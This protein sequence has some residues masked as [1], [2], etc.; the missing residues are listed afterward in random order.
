MAVMNIRGFR[1][2]VWI[3]PS[4]TANWL[5][6]VTM[7]DGTVHDLS[8]FL[9]GGQI[10]DACT[11][12][13]GGFEIEFP[14]ASGQFTG[15]FSGMEIVQ[16][17][18]DYAGGTPSTLRF[19][20]RVEK[21]SLQNH[22]V[23]LSGRSEAL[24]LVD[25][26]VTKTYTNTD[27]AD[28]LRD[29][30]VSYGDGRF[31]TTSIPVSTGVILT[32][33]WRQKSWIECAKDLCAASNREW[34]MTPLLDIELFE[35]NSVVNLDDAV[36]HT[37]NLV[38]VGEFAPDVSQIKNLVRV[39]GASSGSVQVLYT[40]R[41]AA[42]IALYGERELTVQDNTIDRFEAAR[43]YAE[44]LLAQNLAPPIVG[45]VRSVLLATATAGQSLRVSA[46]YDGL[47]ASQYP[48]VKLEHNLVE[49]TTTLTV[50]REPRKL[51]GVLK[52]RIEAQNRLQEVGANPHNLDT[53]FTFTY[54]STTGVLVQT[55]ITG[56]VLRLAAGQS[57]GT[58]TSNV[59]ELGVNLAQVYLNVDVEQRSGAVFE[60]SGNDG[61]TWQTIVP[62]ELTT[63]ATTSGP[64]LRLRV[65]LNDPLT[66]VAGVSLLYSTT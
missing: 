3:P 56:G 10:I 30:V 64:N 19:R 63:I 27:V 51:S 47:S 29:L 18:C 34:R 57:F 36:V 32:V 33:D 23:R 25:R 22:T 8:D 61:V 38:E 48:I 14:N 40:A 11:D 1:P 45:D 16:Y 55:E 24:F 42:S 4:I 58:W 52:D 12:E 28:I 39:F 31:T 41:D 35:R 59:R 50:N 7:N 43:D 2:S 62:R 20:G 66:Q 37:Y 53:S 6:T 15:A 44:Y 26:L 5:L 65:T 46:P 21:P 13:I 49:H 60:V 54:D 9:L 17:Y